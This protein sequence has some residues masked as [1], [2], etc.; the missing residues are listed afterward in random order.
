MKQIKSLL[1]AAA[2][3]IGATSFTNA[4]SKV[5]HINVGELV[6]SMPEMKTAQAEMEQMGKTFETDIQEM[7]NEYKTKA[8]QYEAE[9]ATKTNEDNQKRGEELAGMQQNIRQFQA[10]A[11]QQLQQKELDLLE[12]ITKKAKAAILKVAKAQGFDYVLDSSQGSGVIM[13]EGKNLLQDV[14]K[15]LGF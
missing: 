5:A 13:A 2:L 11:Q 6:T 7:M 12:P 9:A 1:F 14:Q 4:Q 10:N 3:F 15:E 8:Q